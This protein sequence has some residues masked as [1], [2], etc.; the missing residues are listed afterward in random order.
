VGVDVRAHLDLLDL[1]DLLIL[2]RLCGLF[3][4]L[5]LE[6]AEIGDLADGRLGIGRDLDEVET[7]VLR[8]LEGF[9]D[10][11]DAAVRSIDVDQLDPGG[12]DVTVGARPFLD[13]RCGFERSAN[14]RGLLV[15]MMTG[16]NAPPRRLCRC[17]ERSVNSM[18]AGGN[19]GVEEEIDAVRDMPEAEADA[20]RTAA[21]HRRR[22]RETSAAACVGRP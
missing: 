4:A 6:L 10:R 16:V 8:I 21:G 1:D 18:I 5:V 12:P 15:P 3:L 14:G 20:R 17:G 22:R 11:D 13:G 7:L 2:A 19:H 9:L